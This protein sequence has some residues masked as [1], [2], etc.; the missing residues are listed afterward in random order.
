MANGWNPLIGIGFTSL[1]IGY[2]WEAYSRNKTGTPATP[3][4]PITTNG[5]RRRL[6]PGSTGLGY[7]EPKKGGIRSMKMHAVGTIEDRERYIREQIKKD[8]LNPKVISA[9]R[10]VVSG[11]C[12]KADGGV[13]W[14]VKPKDSM[15]EIRLMFK[16]VVDPNSAL[17]V[18]YTRDHPTVDLFP[19]NELL[20]RLPAE[21]CDGMV[22]R[23]GALLR[24]IGFHVR[25]RIVA[26]AGKPKQWAHIYLMVA[27]VPGVADG[28]LPLDPTEPERAYRARNAPFWE[29]GTDQIDPL[30]L[31]GPII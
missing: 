21:D 27:P 17:A 10:A 5:L 11:R 1:G 22:V 26:P 20:D 6:P 7:A 25:T 24:A 29:P 3:A 14:C 8:S 28:W 9:A 12:P 18:R 30:K 19:S 23:L 15:G 31:D 16:A 4:E 13:M 2:L